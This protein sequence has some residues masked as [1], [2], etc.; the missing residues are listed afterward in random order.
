VSLLGHA[1]ILDPLW[2]HRLVR[3]EVDLD[4]KQI[5]CYRLRRK[6][7]EQQPLI[8]TIAYQ[9]PSR[10]FDTRPRRQHPVTE[11]R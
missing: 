3:C 2:Q 8:K 4:Q 9:L 7:P 1:Y 5:R 11:I 10:R 6:E